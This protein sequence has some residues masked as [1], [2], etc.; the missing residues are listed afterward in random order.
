MLI[1][2]SER[3]NEIGLRKAVGARSKDIQM[4]FLLE[5]ITITF[6]GGVIGV[7]LGFIGAKII[8]IITEMPAAYSWEGI[9]T[10]IIFSS[11]VG[12]IAGIQPAK[13]ASALDPIESLRS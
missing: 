5:T 6:I 3:K 9:L 2:V 1:S 11:L 13:K 12:I 8:S 10:G 7:V 4:Q